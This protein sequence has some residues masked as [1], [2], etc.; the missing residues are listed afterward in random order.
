MHE[1]G[2]LDKGVGSQKLYGFL[3]RG[4]YDLCLNL[5]TKNRTHQIRSA[6][7]ER[8]GQR[9]PSTQLTA[10]LFVFT[11]G[12]GPAIRKCPMIFH[13]FIR[14]RFCLEVLA[15]LVRPLAP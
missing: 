15:G 1:G 11:Y 3:R 8:P 9:V 5:F 14:G 6:G 13:V 12:P 7:P 2:K 10:I 4:F